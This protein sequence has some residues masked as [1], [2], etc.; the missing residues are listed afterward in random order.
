[1]GLLGTTFLLPLFFQ[2]IRGA[3]A[4]TSGFL[5]IPF[6]LLNT[7]GAFTGGQ[8]ARRLGRTKAIIITG[9]ALGAWVSPAWRRCGPA[10][11]S[12]W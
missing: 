6:L 8:I 2:L 4:A 12:P 9:F 3:D 1:M 10:R 7:V 11:R 5:V